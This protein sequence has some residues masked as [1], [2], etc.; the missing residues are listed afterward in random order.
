MKIISNKKNQF[1][2]N[3][4]RKNQ[5]KQKRTQHSRRLESSRAEAVE[6]KVSRVTSAR[7][8][9]KLEMMKRPLRSHELCN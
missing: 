8:S 4:R 5:L 3:Y 1:F 6:V 7:A 9:S 2:F